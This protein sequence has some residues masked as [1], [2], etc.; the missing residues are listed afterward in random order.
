MFSY[1][2]GMM[3]CKKILIYDDIKYFLLTS[4]NIP[5]KFKKVYL[6]ALFNIHIAEVEEENSDFKSDDMI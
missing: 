3:L 4:S 2:V 5:F 6:R 1:K